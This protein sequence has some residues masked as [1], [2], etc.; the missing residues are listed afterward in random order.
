VNVTGTITVT[1]PHVT[2][3][4]VCVTDNGAGNVNNGPA[5]SFR[6]VG[7]LIENSTVAGANATDQSVEQAVATT[8]SGRATANHDYFY[9]CG[10]CIH[11]SGWTVENSYVDAN[12]APYSSGYSSGAAQGQADHHEDLYCNNCTV[13]LS[14]D[15]LLNPFDET[16]VLFTD[17]NNGSGGT[18]R[19]RDVL[20]N[21]LLAGGGFLVYECPGATSPGTAS[22]NFTGN[23]VARC[24]TAPVSQTP[25]GGSDCAGNRLPMPGSGAGSGGYWPYGGHYGVHAATYCSGVSGQMWSNNVW[26][27][28]GASVSC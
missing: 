23:A 3:E 12:G 11:D 21:S 1:A 22:V 7:G 20:T 4:N 24:T 16:A 10:E 6:A 25:D 26:D 27:D 19:N 5:V 17:V 28:N 15:T 9:N 18:C 8:N 13:T 14:H 2:I